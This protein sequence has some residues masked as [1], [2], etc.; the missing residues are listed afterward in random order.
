MENSTEHNR[1]QL[2]KQQS[3]LREI[4]MNSNRYNDAMDLF[5]KQ[6]AQLHSG[7]VTQNK[8]WS[9][10]DA[11]LGDLPEEKFR[12]I[13]KNNNHSIAWC[14]WHIARIEDATMNLLVAEEPQVI[15]QNNWLEKMNVNVE[16]TGNGMS[17]VDIKQLSSKINS[18]ALL[19][20]RVVV[21]QKT[22]EIVGS[23]TAEKIT[24]KVEKERIENLLSED[25]LLEDATGLANYWGNRSI[26][27]LLLMPATR[28]NLSHL[29][30]V[31][32]LRKKHR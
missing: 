32:R 11:V 22:R 29:N 23:L 31:M 4:M 17:D 24:Q 12:Q 19:A 28:H 26:A 15:R 13:P 2:Y 1:K 30:E 6:H 8:F 10:A 27:G 16:N 18:E 21:G 3:E 9:F 5:Y 14:I 20:Y 7:N 25:V